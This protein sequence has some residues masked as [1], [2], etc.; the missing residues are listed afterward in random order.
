MSRAL[1]RRHFTMAAAALAAPALLPR[2][3]LASDVQIDLMHPFP[4]ADH[5]IQ[6]L[7]KAFNG[8]GNGVTVSGRRDGTTYEAITRKAMASIAAGR[9]PALMVTGWKLGD[10]AHRILGAHDFREIFGAGRTDA[11]LARFRPTVRPFGYVDGV[12]IGLPWSMSAAALAT[13][14]AL[15]PSTVEQLYPLLRR[16]QDR[17]DDQVVCQQ[18]VEWRPRALLKNASGAVIE[19]DGKPMRDGP[20]AAPRR[21]DTSWNAMTLPRL[22]MSGFAGRDRAA[23]DGNFLAVYSKVKEQQEGAYRFMDFATSREG[24]AIWRASGDDW[25]GR[26]M[27]G[28]ALA[29]A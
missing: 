27:N 18:A 19:V 25:S 22:L 3:A 2:I 10:F 26:I 5:P 12:P 17:P 15:A 13:N 4:G 29:A 8:K 16:L 28:A 11:L 14:P 9:G 1:S 21:A 7:I 24:F 6:R 23:F 20:A